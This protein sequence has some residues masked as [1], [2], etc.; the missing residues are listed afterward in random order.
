MEHEHEHVLRIILVGELTLLDGGAETAGNVGVAGVR[1]VA[2]DVCRHAALADEH[3]DLTAAG[4]GVNNEVLLP[5]AQDLGDRRIGLAVSGEPAGGE[6]VA[7]FNVFF[8][9]V[10]Q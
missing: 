8:N 1:G 5:L 7:V 3:I 6:Y 10:V 4:A 2:V 9:G